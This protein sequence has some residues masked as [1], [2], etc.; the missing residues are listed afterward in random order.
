MPHTHVH[1]ETKH[2][3]WMWKTSTPL[4]QTPKWV[5]EL[6]TKG[7]LFIIHD[8]LLVRNYVD[9]NVHAVVP[10]GYYI[11]LRGSDDVTIVSNV[12]VTFNYVEILK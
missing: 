1:K 7:T 11:E 5:N 2:L 12:M 9:M 10:E 3:L 8:M 4:G 6:L